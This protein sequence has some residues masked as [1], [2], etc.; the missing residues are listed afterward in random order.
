MSSDNT[1]FCYNGGRRRDLRC[2]LLENGSGNASCGED[3]RILSCGS[4]VGECRLCV[5]QLSVRHWSPLVHPG[6]GNP[7]G[8]HALPSYETNT[9]ELT[10]EQLVMA[11][12]FSKLKL[13]KTHACSSPLSVHCVTPEQLCWLGTD[14]RLRHSETVVSLGGLNS[15][16]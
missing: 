9:D 3:W 11:T 6:L 12:Y 16:G 5:L 10:G 8:R 2:H 13:Y 7:S 14:R 15:E 1:S 4:R